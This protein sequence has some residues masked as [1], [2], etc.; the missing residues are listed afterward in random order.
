MLFVII[1]V[2]VIFAVTLTITTCL[3]LFY[4]HCHAFWDFL[5]C[6][7]CLS[8]FQSQFQCH[9][10][11][12]SHCKCHWYY[13]PN[14]HCLC[15]SESHCH[16]LSLQLTKLLAL[17]LSLS[18][19]PSQTLTISN[20][21]IFSVCH[22][23]CLFHCQLYHIISFSVTFT[24]SLNATV[25]LTVSSTLTL[26][27]TVITSL[28][29]FLS[30]IV[31]LSLLLS[32]SDSH[33][34]LCCSCQSHWVFVNLTEIEAVRVTKRKTVRET[35]TVAL[36]V[37]WQ[38][39]IEWRWVTKTLMVSIDRE[40]NNGGSDSYSPNE[41]AATETVREKVIVQLND[42]DWLWKRRWQSSDSES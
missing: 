39:W 26:S 19:S 33:L 35:T 12:D 20:S 3:S 21:V 8:L 25:T 36:T 37:K 1:T 11:F 5:C 17:S 31:L 28:S 4:N 16:G 13:P 10:H 6:C 29:F 42:G 18:D 15:H 23:S 14:C 27:I 40:N 34:T 2:A 38:G 24:V 30:L 7:F 41:A 22:F 32:L 9:S